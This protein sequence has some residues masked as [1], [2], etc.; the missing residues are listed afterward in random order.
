M[1]FVKRC[2]EYVKDNPEGY[3]FKRKLFGWGWTPVTWQGWLV[4]V[5]LIAFVV[6]RGIVFDT[7]VMAGNTEPTQAQLLWF[8]AQVFGAI[9]VLIVI[10]WRTGETPKWQWG[11]PK[12]EDKI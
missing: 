9:L 6:W 11:I 10:A 4:T 12:K 2:I 5:A 8:F 3:W 7:V 1:N